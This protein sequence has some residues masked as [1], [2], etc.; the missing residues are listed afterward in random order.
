MPRVLA[1]QHSYRVDTILSSL[2]KPSD[3]S[4]AMTSTHASTGKPPPAPS[5]AE[6]A[7]VV[8]KCPRP[9]A[10][11]DEDTLNRLKATI[12]ETIRVAVDTQ[13]RAQM[14]F[15]LAIYGK[16]FGK[17]P[18]FEVVKTTLLGLW[19]YLGTFQISDMPNGYILARCSSEQSKQQ[20]HFE[21]PWTV[22][23]LQVVQSHGMDPASQPSGG[24][25]GH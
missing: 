4:I 8:H 10:P 24:V 12:T 22:N 9:L 11:L 7:G 1:A 19:K 3:H 21:G 2:T 6:V 15:Q 13:M 5:W 18:H 23:G 14:H 20:I 16:L 17:S 25:L